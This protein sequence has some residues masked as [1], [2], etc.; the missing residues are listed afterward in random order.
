[1][2]IHCNLLSYISGERHLEISVNISGRILSFAY[3]PL[4]NFREVNEIKNITIRSK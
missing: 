3:A 1:M 4:I 2:I